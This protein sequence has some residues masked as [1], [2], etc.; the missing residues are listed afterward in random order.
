[1]RTFVALLPMVLLL[2]LGIFLAL[3]STALIGDLNNL[4]ETALQI[5]V[6]NASAL[7]IAM[8]AAQ[9]RALQKPTAIAIALLVIAGNVVCMSG[10]TS[11]ISRA[12]LGATATS[13]VFGGALLLVA[14]ATG[15]H[16]KG[17]TSSPDG[18]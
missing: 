7:P 4:T 2:C 12:T 18:P 11:E 10:M 16:R 1:M 13:L 9:G 3:R 5:A 8:L 14:G 15:S 17:H 6:L